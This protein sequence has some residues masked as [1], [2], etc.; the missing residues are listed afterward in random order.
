M[1]GRI[2]EPYRPGTAH[3]ERASAASLGGELPALEADFFRGSKHA[4]E[5]TRVCVRPGGLILRPERR[6][7]T[8]VIDSADNDAKDF[9]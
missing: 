5:I 1:P 4:W 9:R 7:S 2:R 6:V 8:G 3:Y